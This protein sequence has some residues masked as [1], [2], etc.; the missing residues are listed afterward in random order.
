MSPETDSHDFHYPMIGCL[1]DGFRFDAS[2]SLND[3]ERIR[4]PRELVEDITNCLFDDR[5]MLETCSLVVATTWLPARSRHHF[6][7]TIS[8]NGRRARRWCS[9]IRHDTD[10]V[11]HFARTLMPQQPQGHRWLETKF[12]DTIPDHFSSFR[13]VGN[14]FIAWLDP[15]NFKQGRSPVTSFTMGLLHAH[16]ICLTSLPIIRQ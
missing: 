9:A 4:L 7:N 6:F 3:V 11:S 10:S 13:H 14:M 12:L 1:D 5:Q 8:L 2:R 15:G 16:S